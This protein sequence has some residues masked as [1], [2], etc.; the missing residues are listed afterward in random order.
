MRTLY[1]NAGDDDNDD[2]PS[3]DAPPAIGIWTPF[4][5]CGFN[6]QVGET[7]LVYATGDEE[8]PVLSTSLCSRT[9][10]LTDS[11]ED[12]GYLFYYLNQPDRSTRLDGFVTTN[13]LYQREY[14]A[15]NFTGAIAQP[16]AGATVELRSEG[17][18]RYAETDAGGRFT[19]DGLAAGD[20]STT[21]YAPGFP[22]TR[23]AV[24]GPRKISVAV[25]SCAT[26]VLLAPRSEVHD[27]QK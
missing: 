2:D 14:D 16:V 7:Y 21:A 8:S 26:Q 13:E 22:E 6:F 4:G 17:G 23:R 10:R 3:D 5:E 1:R 27:A 9:R 15:K 12:L 25:K 19:F 18:A 11:G 20:Y 24:A